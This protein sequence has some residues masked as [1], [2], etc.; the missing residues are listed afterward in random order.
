MRNTV[1]CG[2]LAGAVAA[3]SAQSAAPVAAV[4]ASA[5]Q[6]C[7]I[8]AEPA[9]RLACYD[10]IALPGLGSRSGWGAPVAGAAAPAATAVPAPGAAPAAAPG[11]RFGLPARRSDEADTLES[12]IAG[13]V[14]Y[15]ENGTQFTLQNGQVWQIVDNIR[16]AYELQDPPVRIER[17]A[18]GS[19]VM[20]IEGVSQRPRVRRIR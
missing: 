15:F 9:A 19:F 16:G 4:D 14:T 13:A 6:R 10:A 11:E 3:V 17:A 5:V 1:L 20:T 18:L 2:L 12:R 8:I 7:R